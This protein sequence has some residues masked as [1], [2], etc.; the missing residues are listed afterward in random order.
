MEIRWHKLTANLTGTEAQQK[1]WSKI[2]Q[3]LANTKHRKYYYN[4]EYLERRFN[5]YD[6]YVERLSNPSAVALAMFFQ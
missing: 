2:C 1:W 6:Q 5:L 4:L 3:T